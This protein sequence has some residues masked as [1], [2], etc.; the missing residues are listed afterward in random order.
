MPRMRISER[1]SMRS[2]A[3]SNALDAAAI[4][5]PAALFATDADTRFHNA[6]AS[7]QAAKNP[8]AGREETAQAGKKL[9]VRN[10]LSCHGK[11]GNGTGN[12]PSLVDGRVGWV[13]AG[14]VLWFIKWGNKDKGMPAWGS[15]PAKQRWEIVTY[16]ESMGTSP[17][18]PEAS[19][20]P[21]PDLNPSKLKAP[22]P[23]PPFTDFRYEKPGT[24]HKITVNDL[25]QPYATKSAYK[26]PLPVAR[27]E[28][29]WPSAPAGFKVELYGA[30]LDNPRT[31]RTAPNGDIF[32]AESDPGRIRIFRGLTAGGKPE[33]SAIFVSGL[34]QPY[35]LAFY[36]PGPDPQWL[37]VGSAAE[38][39]RFPYHSGDLQPSGPPQHI[40]DLPASWFGHTTR[41]VE[42]SRDGKRMFVAVGSGSNVDDP[43]THPG[44]KN[45]SAS[46]SCDPENCVL[47]L[48]ATSIRKADAGV[49]A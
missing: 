38:V 1:G 44:E 41:A 42:F 14:G 45:R 49:R 2:L 11:T 27:P 28:N 30:G 33:Q 40:A 7:A 43:D 39:V 46:L 35:G 6:P 21:P 48:Y 9:Y 15:L 4:L 3:N 22:P 18:A 36:P 10:C 37:Y 12:V 24:F 47:G 17:A 23:T 20:P 25:P 26:F 32:L 34:K 19:A 8:Y 16:I 31:L 13:W 29:V 5:L